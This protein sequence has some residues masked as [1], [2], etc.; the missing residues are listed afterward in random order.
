MKPDGSIDMIH[1]PEKKM[2]GVQFHPESVMTENG[3][4]ILE[5]LLLKLNKYTK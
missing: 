4:E 3:R 5:N 1:C 2:L